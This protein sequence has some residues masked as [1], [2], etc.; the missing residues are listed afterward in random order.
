MQ[1][2][3]VP[4][5]TERVKFEVMRRT[6]DAQVSDL[7]NTLSLVIHACEEVQNSKNFLKI[8]EIVLAVGNYLN[9]S[10]FRGGAWGFKIDVLTK[11]RLCVRPC[12]CL[13]SVILFFV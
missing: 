12:C 4:R 6:F 5:L 11:V 3:Q 8:V 2:G 1:I 13:I 10:T 9:G 7:R